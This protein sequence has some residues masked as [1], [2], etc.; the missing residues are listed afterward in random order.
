MDEL[1]TQG[2]FALFFVISVGLILGR[3]KIKGFSLDVSGVIFIAMF[4]GYLGVEIP[5]MFQNFGILL[6][7]FTIGIQSGP[8]FFNSFVSD[9]KKPILLTLVLIGSGVVLTLIF[10]AIFDLG[11]IGSILGVFNGGMAS[12]IGLAASI[13]VVSSPKISLDY[14]VIYPFSIIITILFFQLLPLFSKIDFSKENEL[15]AEDVRKKNPLIVRKDY[16][17]ENKNIDGKSIKDLNFRTSTGATISRIKHDGE[18]INPSLGTTVCLGDVLRVVGTED[19]MKR[20]SLLLGKPVENENMD[21]ESQYENLWLLVTNK[22]VVGKTLEEINLSGIFNSNVIRLQRGGTDL[23][24]SG[25]IKIR[26][27]DKLYVATDISH[28]EAVTEFLG[29][30]IKQVADTDFLPITLGI[31]IGIFIGSLTI[32]IHESFQLKL[33]IGGGVLISSLV[34]SYIGKTGPIIWTMNSVSNNLFRQLG[35]L[36]F[37]AAVGTEAGTHLS[38]VLNVHSLVVVG[39]GCLVSI[40]PMIISYFVGRYVFKVSFIPLVGIIAGAL[41][42]T[43][44][45]T[46]IG[47]KTK[48]PNLQA[49]YATAYPFALVLMIIIPQI[50][51]FFFK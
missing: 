13:D 41:N 9:G 43:L 48:S 10:C 1:F 51:V 47:V 42:S 17:V 22:R 4:L 11:D 45:L 20:A 7:I 26:Y 50:L 16:L 30:N 44:G 35:L 23:S 46:I 37:L 32:P 27:G 14:S 36:I 15:D 12:S 2:L 3:L 39:I 40:L 34:L 33:G 6:F 24:I 21:L 31:I 18:V 49:N 8:G 5:Q 19:S 38:D 25:K 29:N 28:A